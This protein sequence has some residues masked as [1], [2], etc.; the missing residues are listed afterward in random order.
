MQ[1]IERPT[2]LFK[3]LESADP[4]DL[5]SRVAAGRSNAWAELVQT[6]TPLL[7]ARVRRYQLQDAD[8]F[9]VMQTTWVRLSENLDRIH[10]P[11][12]LAGWLATVVSRECLRV[13]RMQSRT[14]LGDEF[15]LDQADEGQDPE[16]RAVDSADARELHTAIADLPP[17]RQALLAALFAGDGKSYAE[18]AHDLDIPVGSLGPTRARTLRELRRL[19]E[20]RGVTR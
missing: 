20:R 8:A 11:Q 5:L 7:R 6:Y 2:A 9:D 19:L 16:Q 14:V 1:T 17:Q 3:S 12:H 18:I 4:A 10:T 15:G 13:L